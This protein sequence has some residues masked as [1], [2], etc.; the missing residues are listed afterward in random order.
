[1]KWSH[2]GVSFLQLM[3]KALV[4]YQDNAFLCERVCFLLGNSLSSRS[5]VF[6]PLFYLSTAHMH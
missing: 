2:E 6:V 5:F 4:L 3:T 1:M